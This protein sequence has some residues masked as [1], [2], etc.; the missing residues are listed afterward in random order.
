MEK[1]ISQD[2]TSPHTDNFVAAPPDYQLLSLTEAGED[3][4]DQVVGPYA[5]DSEVKSTDCT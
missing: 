3:M 2:S 1:P 4:A 5:A